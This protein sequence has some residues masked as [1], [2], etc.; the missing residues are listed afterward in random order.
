MIEWVSERETIFHSYSNTVRQKERVL[1]KCVRLCVCVCVLTVCVFVCEK[2]RERE[3]EKERGRKKQN[4]K[5]YF[6]EIFCERR[7][8]NSVHVWLNSS[9][10]SSLGDLKLRHFGNFTESC[11]FNSQTWVN[12][13]I[14]IATNTIVSESPILTLNNIRLSTAA[15]HHLRMAF[16]N[17]F[18]YIRKRQSWN[19]V[20][21]SDL[22]DF[23]NLWNSELY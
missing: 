4:V 15:C 13:Y 1:Y 7:R 3:I 11:K 21:L 18:D 16:V 6:W 9:S 8:K 19:F 2:E 17:M 12:D 14:W 10:S 22:R 5:K 20:L 23:P